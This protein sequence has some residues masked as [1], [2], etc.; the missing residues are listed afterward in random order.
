MALAQASEEEHGAGNAMY[1]P[2]L[3]ELDL[4]E[5]KMDA[6]ISWDCCWDILGDIETSLRLM[7][8]QG[9]CQV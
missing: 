3:T 7:C 9:S 2:N 6:E 5:S 8:T 4:K 1:G